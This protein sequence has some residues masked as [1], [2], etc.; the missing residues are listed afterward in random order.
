MQ[1]KMKNKGLADIVAMT[2][3]VLAVVA[4]TYILFSYVNS[5]RTELSPEISCFEIE[6]DFPISFSES[7]TCINTETNEI[8][9]GLTRKVSSA[10][11]FIG[12]LDFYLSSDSDS[13]EFKCGP[14]CGG[15]CLILEATGNTE[16]YYLPLNPETINEEITLNLGVNSCSPI[17]FSS[18][19]KLC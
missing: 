12:S 14:S 10:D 9:I 3:L 19:I 1:N 2:L 7:E 18:D 5:A 15:G 11:L 8:Q 13:S 16:T 4:A 17:K 6:T